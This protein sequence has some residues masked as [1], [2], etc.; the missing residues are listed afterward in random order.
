V[1]FL[2]L[3]KQRVFVVLIFLGVSYALYNY[4]FVGVNEQ[5]DNYLSELNKVKSGDIAIVYNSIV[6]THSD[7]GVIGEFILDKPLLAC[8]KE[9]E[10][11]VGRFYSDNELILATADSDFLIQIYLD[12]RK[13]VSATVYRYLKGDSGRQGI[14]ELKVNCDMSSYPILDTIYEIKGS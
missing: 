2:V 14:A 3:I 12:N 5:K 9:G 6:K 1:G 10:I 8:L 11:N 7:E 13:A 4:D